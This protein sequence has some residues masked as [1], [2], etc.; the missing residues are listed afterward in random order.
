MTWEYKILTGTITSGARVTIESRSFPPPDLDEELNRFAAQGYVVESF[1]PF[2][3][4][5]GGGS[6]VLFTLTGSRDVVV[7][8]KRMRK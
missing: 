8:L 7:L 4:V 5:V 3:S 6:S 2:S 1:Q